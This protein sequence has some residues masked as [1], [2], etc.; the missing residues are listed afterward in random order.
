MP[1]NEYVETADLLVHRVLYDLVENEIAPG[2]GITA[3]AFFREL[4]GL[5]DAMADRNKSFLKIRDAIQAQIDGY[6]LSRK[7]KPWDAAGYEAFLKKIGYLLPQPAPFKVTTSKVDA[8][9]ATTPGPQLVVPVDNARFAVNA[10]NARW[11]R[12]GSLLDAFYGTDAGPPETDGAEKGTTYNP[13][14]GAKVFEY[15]YQF[16]DQTFPLTNGAKYTQVKGYGVGAGNKLE[17]T[18]ANGSKVELKDPAQFAGFQKKAPGSLAS[19]FLKHNGLHLEIVVNPDSRIGKTNPA[20]VSD[21]LLEAA[22]TTIADMEDSV[23]S[24]DAHDKARVYRNWNGLVRGTLSAAFTKDGKQLSRLLNKDKHF[25]APDGKQ[26]RLP[27]RSLLLVRNVGIHMYTDMVLRKKTQE[28]V[29]EGMVDAMVSALAAKPDLAKGA[30]GSN[31]RQG[32]MYIVKPKMHGPDEVAFTVELFGRVEKALGLPPLTIKLGIMDEERRT[33]VNLAECIRRAQD[34]CIFINT[35]FLDRTGDEIHTSMEAGPMLNKDGIKKAKWRN[36]YELWNVEVGLRC[37]L[38]GVGQI[39]KGM[40]AQPDE[41]KAMLATKGEHPRAGATTAWVP[42]PTGATLH[43]IHY[44]QVDVLAVQRAMEAKGD[45]ITFSDLLLPPLMETPLSKQAIQK[46][47]ENNC[48]GLLGYV[49]RWVQQGIGCSKVPDLTD[50][51]L[52]E[53]RATL[54]INAQLIYNWYKHGLVTKEDV[55]G[56]LKKMAEVVDRQNKKDSRYHNM[57]PAFND[58]AFQCANRLIFGAGE[59]PNGYTE[60]ALTEYRRATKRGLPL[61]LSKL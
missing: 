47:M 22:V 5:I 59:D 40:W 18:L 45:R 31:S 61:A 32:S 50:V 48:Q 33:T 34:R 54:R 56:C 28:S 12:W 27:G 38:L 17:C 1:K 4:S 30:E 52:M 2:T 23:S 26:V 25:T 42:S 29:P 15:A 57:A 41:M 21:I 37:G 20:G 13:K 39:G 7:G 8:E 24:V 11:G 44:H 53:D 10:A 16:M 55:M 60:F 46:E 36:A 51:G 19:V 3:Q 43:A 35:G 14:R 6:L 58:L 49:V 9:I